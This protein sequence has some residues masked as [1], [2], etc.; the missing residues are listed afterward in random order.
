M[1]S[2]HDKARKMKELLF[3]EV[4][5]MYDTAKTDIE[6]IADQGNAQ[7]ILR[8]VEN[9]VRKRPEIDN[10]IGKRSTTGKAF[11]DVLEDLRKIA[12]DP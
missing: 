7:E 4:D 6:K 3:K 10:I 11:A 12:E 2:Q 1:S 5:G 9:S 8:F